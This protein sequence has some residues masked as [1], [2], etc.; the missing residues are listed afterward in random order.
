MSLDDRLGC[1]SSQG[2]G[3]IHHVFNQSPD[4]GVDTLSHQRGDLPA[5]PVDN[6]RSDVGAVGA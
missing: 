1:G 3:G 4:A 2:V 6:G 5:R